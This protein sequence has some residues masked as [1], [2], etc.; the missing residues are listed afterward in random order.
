M[1]D[2]DAPTSAD[3]RLDWTPKRSALGKV[4]FWAIAAWLLTR[5]LPVLALSDV[6]L[7]GEEL[8]K[9]AVGVLLT[10]YFRGELDLSWASLP[11]HPYEGGGFF[12]SHMKA[13]AF[14]FVGENLLAHKL[15]ALVWGALVLAAGIRFTFRHF[16]ARTAAWFGAL[17]VLAPLPLVRASLL[18]LGI[19][20][21]A[22]AFV[23]LLF[24]QGLALAAAEV[25]RQESTQRWGWRA[26]FGLGVIAGFGLWFSLQLVLP[27]ALVVLTLALVHPRQ[28]FGR[29]GLLGL[30]GCVLGAAPLLWIAR[31][32]GAGVF[33]IHGE[34]LGGEGGFARLGSFLASAARAST[35]TP[36]AAL[37]AVALALL[38]AAGLALALGHATTRRVGGFVL[39]Y[40]VTWLLLAGWSGF[41]PERL[42]HWFQLLRWSPPLALVLVFAAHGAAWGHAALSVATA[43]AVNASGPEADERVGRRIAAT[44]LVTCAALALVAG[45]TRIVGL[46]REGDLGRARAHWAQLRATPG[47]AWT[48]ASMKLVPRLVGRTVTAEPPSPD[49]LAPWVRAARELTAGTLGGAD[50]ALALLTSIG[51]GYAQTSRATFDAAYDVLMSVVPTSVVATSVV[52]TSV[53]PTSVVPTS[54]VPTSVVPTSV[55]PTSVVPTSVV[56]GIADAQDPRGA[57]VSGGITVEAQRRALALGLGQ[58]LAE[59]RGQGAPWLALAAVESAPP[60]RG[61]TALWGE[62]LGRYGPGLVL[63]ASEL[64]RELEAVR[65]LAGAEAYRRGLGVRAY[66]SIVLAPYGNLGGL[67]LTLRPDRFRA[68]LSTVAPAAEAADVRAGFDAAEALRSPR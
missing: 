20:F 51:T 31:T 36:W 39:V 27:C 30:V 11:Y 41:V 2:H 9:G 68:W 19:H 67:G 15:C 45:A 34:G 42:A 50:A 63:F 56:P 3:G 65:G 37:Q 52:P 47:T 7:Y 32:A 59:E 49:A 44:A 16:G 66:E 35:A 54:V 18:H 17:F 13:L 29:G 26:P 6:F 14:L 40:L 12:A 23:F 24:D 21:E 43:R 4:T 55:V 28:V 1:Q 10:A 53:V 46:V 57:A 5:A 33:D 38:S 48:Q 62:A 22:L 64:A 61:D 8:E 58:R 25:P 60:A